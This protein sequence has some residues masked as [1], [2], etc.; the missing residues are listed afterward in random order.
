MWAIA[1]YYNPVGYRRRP[2]V[3][4]EFRRRLNVPLATVEWSRDE[5]FELSDSD[6]D[7][8]IQIRGHDVLWQKECLL[9]IAADNLPPECDCIAWLDCDVIFEDEDWGPRAMELL[10]RHPVIHL[11]REVADLPA[12]TDL[13]RLPAFPARPAARSL[14]YGVRHATVD[15]ESLA[16]KSTRTN[17]GWSTGLGW[18]MRRSVWRRHRFYDACIVGGGDRAMACAAHARYDVPIRRFRMNAM[19]QAHYLDWAKNY[20]EDVRDN[21]GFLD[22][23]VFHLWHGDVATRRN[24]AKRFGG[25][26]QFEFDPYRD[27]ALDDSG[28]W[29]WSTDRPGL[30]RFVEEYF[31]SRRED[32]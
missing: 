10:E 4:R 23:R 26:R 18:A 17:C 8:L 24:P 2:A 9:N 30:H 7:I 31:E 12:D 16:T 14:V 11:F 5:Q 27:I 3:Y 25:L 1:A 15:W 19:Q 21:V 13:T 20:Y 28:C 29:R 22:N 32:G 6:A